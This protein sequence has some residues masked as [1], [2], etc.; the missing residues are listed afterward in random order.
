[1]RIRKSLGTVLLVAGLAALGGCSSAPR[2][3][4]VQSGNGMAAG[5][6][7]VPGER[8]SMAAGDRLGLAVYATDRAIARRE[9]RERGAVASVPTE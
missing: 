5:D 1:M 8:I 6:G 4:S 9:A 2:A 7:Y 3:A